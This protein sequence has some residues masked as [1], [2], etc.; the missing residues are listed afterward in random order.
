MLSNVNVIST[1]RNTV[2]KKPIN[3]Q[4]T[5]ESKLSTTIIANGTV[6]T[7]INNTDAKATVISYDE[8]FKTYMLKTSDNKTFSLSSATLKDKRKWTIIT[9]VEA[10]VPKTETEKVVEPTK[11]ETETNKITSREDYK[12]DKVADDNKI[13]QYV[14]NKGVKLGGTVF[15]PATDMNFRSIKIGSHMFAK[16]SYSKTTCTVAV[17]SNS[18]ESLGLA[19]KKCNHTF[20]AA[21]KFNTLD[22]D[23]K[24]L[25]DTVLKSAYTEL[26]TRGGKRVKT[27]K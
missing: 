5:E 16:I 15:S 11:V 13:L 18:I 12:S 1:T 2:P 24:K 17:R 9:D 7:R 20:D 10:E 6:V 4:K 19:Y 21:F 22:T 25:I 26:N 3:T 27:T 14:L 8:K 23:T